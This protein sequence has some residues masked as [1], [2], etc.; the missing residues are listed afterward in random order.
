[1]SI[2]LHRHVSE[3]RTKPAIFVSR[4]G[5]NDLAGCHDDLDSCLYGLLFT[6]ARLFAMLCSDYT[7]ATGAGQAW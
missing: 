2:N 7:M 3:I 6:I 4:G 1:M 5:I